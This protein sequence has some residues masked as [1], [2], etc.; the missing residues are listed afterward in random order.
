M[1]ASFALFAAKSDIGSYKASPFPA[2]L[3]IAR[4]ASL[5]QGCVL[6]PGIGE[7]GKLFF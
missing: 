3:Q 1:L 7:W 5:H 6:V 4:N 2:W